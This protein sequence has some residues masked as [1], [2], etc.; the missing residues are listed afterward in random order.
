MQNMDD[1]Q[2]NPPI[3]PMPPEAKPISDKPV[4]AAAEAQ[5]QLLATIMDKM[6]N[7]LTNPLGMRELRSVNK[8]PTT[9]EED[10]NLLLED[11]QN[12]KQQ[13]GQVR[14][15]VSSKKVPIPNVRTRYKD[16][17]VSDFNDTDF[18]L[19]TNPEEKPST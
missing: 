15:W 10:L 6:N 4:E 18:S 11:L 7:L 16:K 9:P 19:P 14:S 13:I 12:F 17:Y 1:Y 5:E 2:E 3:E 8:A